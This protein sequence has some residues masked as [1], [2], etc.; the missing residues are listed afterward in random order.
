MHS[1]EQYCGLVQRPTDAKMQQED[2]A[3]GTPAP[4]RIWVFGYGSLCWCPG[5]KYKRTLIGHVKGY[6]R[7]FWQGN[8]THRGTED[9]VNINSLCFRVFIDVWKWDSS[10]S[11]VTGLV[12]IELCV[13]Y[14]NHTGSYAQPSSYRMASGGI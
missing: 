2:Q 11:I 7:K 13:L 8:T 9:K 3:T 14:S 1:S 6:S 12:R 4:L 5:F 10:A